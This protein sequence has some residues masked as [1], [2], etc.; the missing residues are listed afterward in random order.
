MR[1]RPIKQQ[2]GMGNMTSGYDI[3]FDAVDDIDE[4]T[5]KDLISKLKQQGND[6]EIESR[7]VGSAALPAETI[8]LLISVVT[9]SMA[10]LAT[11]AAFIYRVFRKGVILDMT[12]RKPR[13]T[14]SDDLPRGSLLILWRDGRQELREGLSDDKVGELMNAAV[15]ND[16]KS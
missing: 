12:R 11:V 2:G 15:M 4:E 1:L 5:A 8:I 13:I 6:A 9:A 3:A 14:K 16:S 7:Y 10:G